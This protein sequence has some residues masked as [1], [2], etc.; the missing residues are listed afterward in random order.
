MAESELRKKLLYKPEN[1]YDTL[2]AEDEQAMWK[3][4]EEYK[5]FL[6]TSKTE[7]ESVATAIYLAETH[8]F[9]EW[10]REE[11]LHAGDKMY[12]VNRDKAIMLAVI[13]TEPLSAGANIAAAHT[14]SPRLDLKPRPLF[15][16]RRIC[17]R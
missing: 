5:H 14:D 15:V 16:S 2:T 3:Y 1:A 12:Y 17:L 7:R 11:A 8:G 10:K 9:R 4:C 13:G 6:D